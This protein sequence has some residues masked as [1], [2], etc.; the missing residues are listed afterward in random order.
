MSRFSR[1]LIKQEQAHDKGWERE[2]LR[3]AKKEEE[4]KRSLLIY[5]R[6]K[7]GKKR[8]KTECRW[9]D[10]AKIL[11]WF[12]WGDVEQSE[13][14]RKKKKED[15]RWLGEF[16]NL[17]T[18]CISVSA[19][20]MQIAACMSDKKARRAMVFS[21]SFFFSEAH[22]PERC[23][24]PAYLHPSTQ[25][26]AADNTG[27]LT[28]KGGIFFPCQ[29]S[30]SEKSQSVFMTAGEVMACVQRVILTDN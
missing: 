4:E 11:R 1:L 9:R 21:F 12:G 20:Y 7:R 29:S 17:S 13:G 5:L 25:N 14:E 23:Q 3:K 19:I 30:I 10:F 8:Y 28:L 27:H 16:R 18:I 15:R 22:Y 6:Q 24:A 2:K 26:T